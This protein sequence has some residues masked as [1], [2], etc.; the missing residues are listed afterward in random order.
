[1]VI[2]KLSLPKISNDYILVKTKAGKV[3][4][5]SRSKDLAKQNISSGFESHRLEAC[6]F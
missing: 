3:P 4:I 5:F 6:S 1:M 2:R